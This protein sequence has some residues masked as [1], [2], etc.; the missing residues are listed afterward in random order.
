MS[1]D[2]I[3]E[4]LKR[5]GKNKVLTIEEE[6]DLVTKA[7]AGDNRAKK[8][9]IKAN[10][11]L[12]VSVASKYMRGNMPYMYIIQEGNIGL[13]KAIEK[14]NPALGYKLSTYA[15]GWIKCYIRRGI[16]K[17]VNT[18]RLPEY[19]VTKIRQFKQAYGELL[20]SLNREP[21]DTELADAM[22]VT[23]H[24]IEI[25]RNA[26]YNEVPLSLDCQTSPNHTMHDSSSDICMV[27]NIID[28]TSNP[29]DEAIKSMYKEGARAI[30]SKLAQRE[31]FVILH[32]WG[33]FDGIPKSCRE[34]GVLMDVSRETVRNIE[35]YA[36]NKLRKNKSIQALRGLLNEC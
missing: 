33:L 25:T 21:T 11:K 15:T 26:L 7:Q 2:L 10:L 36:M 24:I 6:L 35:T 16:S 28:E 13:L 23:Q 14:F 22:N 20:Q 1:E 4:Y 18:V 3:Q 9:L 29:I 5:L 31:K 32:R 30:L 34:I 19:M 8:K 27:D 17:T 12:V